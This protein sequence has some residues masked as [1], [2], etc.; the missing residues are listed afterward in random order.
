MGVLEDIILDIG[1]RTGISGVRRHMS[2]T[3]VEDA[4]R[5]ILLDNP[6][7]A[8]II[9]GFYIPQPYQLDPLPETGATET[10]GPPGAY[11]LGK[12]LKKLGWKVTY[13]V[14][15]YATFAFKGQLGIADDDVVEFPITNDEASERFAKEL[16]ADRKPSVQIAIE[17]PGVTADGRYL[18]VSGGDVTERTAKID[19]L[20]K[21]HHATVGIGDWGNEMGLANLADH[22]R[23]ALPTKAPTVTGST[24]PVIAGVS[25]WGAYAVVAAMSKLT[26]RNLLPHPDME[27]EYIQRMV[28]QGMVE[29]GGRSEYIIDGFSLDENRKVLDSLWDYLSSQGITRF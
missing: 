29:G 11:F 10:D 7:H 5:F 1:K 3:F 21:H 9:T 26:R 23:D 17:R 15:R 8:F 12:A 4:A 6:K 22:T 25:N 27:I 19:Y 14:D 28:A 18:Y 16:L 13:V 24:Y 2:D 20:F